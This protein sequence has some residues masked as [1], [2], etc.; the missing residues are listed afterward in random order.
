[1]KR[2]FLI[3]L[4]LVTTL[5]SSIIAIAPGAS[6]Y[7]TC[8]Q[9]DKKGELVDD[10]SECGSGEPSDNELMKTMTNI[11]NVIVGVV[12]FITVIMIIVGGIMYAT[13]AGDAGKAKKAKDTIMYGL[14]GLVIAILAF[15][16][17]NFVLANI[18]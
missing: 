10:K 12:G 7:Y 16:I 3:V 4:T 13:S 15:G 14:I 2:K 6:A 1:M 9:G 8:S 5:L 18:G 17:V 11:I